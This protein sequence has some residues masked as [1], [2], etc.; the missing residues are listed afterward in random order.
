MAVNLTGN[1]L[2][3]AR[4][5]SLTGT[6]DLAPRLDP[7]TPLNTL[8]LGGGWVPG[9]IQLE[10]ATGTVWQIDL[11]SSLTVGDVLNEINTA[12]G[13]A[14]TATISAGGESLTLS[15]V[16]PLTVREDGDGTTAASLGLHGPS[17]PG[18]LIGHDIRPP[19][20]ALTAL[21]DIESL[22]AGLPLGSVEIEWQ[23]S[24]YTVDFSA[25]AT[26]GDLQTAVAAAVPG[27]E[28]HIN[29]SGLSLVGGSTEEFD[30]RNADATDTASALGLLGMGTPVRLFG[31]FEDLM[32]DLVANDQLAVR[33]AASELSAVADVVQELL[34]RI[35]NRQN[36][37]DWSESILRSRDERLR[38]NLGLEQDVDIAE[39]ATNLSRAQAA[40]QAS[41]SVTST[42]FQ[43]NLMQYL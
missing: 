19:A 10:D 26:L 9:V 17:L 11:S 40:Y 28:L 1:T 23:G 5:G 37:L 29:P 39:V 27:M 35:G 25:A 14:V 43:M 13:G 18:T 38:T 8:N 20:A 30:V 12:T 6:M 41:L 4:S 3:G 21:A 22:A 24:I 34:M 31:V 36:N 15:G 42:L 33:G 16:G 7:T 2:I 32:A